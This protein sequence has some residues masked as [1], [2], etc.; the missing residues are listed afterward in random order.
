MIFLYSNLEKV[1]RKIFSTFECKHTN[2]NLFAFNDAIWQR[3]VLLGTA[4]L[5]VLKIPQ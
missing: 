1:A 2:L 5:P 3:V 4:E